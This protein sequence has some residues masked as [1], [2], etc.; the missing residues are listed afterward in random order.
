MVSY[1]DILD[2]H[3]VTYNHIEIDSRYL[4]NAYKLLNDDT[5]LVKSIKKNIV[6][7]P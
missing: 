7:N 4:L 1:S 6:D 5:I 3:I 2:D